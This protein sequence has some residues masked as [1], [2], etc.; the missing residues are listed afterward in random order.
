M[1]ESGLEF[2]LLDGRQAEQFESERERFQLIQSWLP[3]GRAHGPFWEMHATR[4]D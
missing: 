2:R 1:T 4:V 3:N